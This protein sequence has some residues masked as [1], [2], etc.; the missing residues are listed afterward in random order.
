MGG[1]SDTGSTRS[2]EGIEERPGRVTQGDGARNT[3][4]GGT[5]VEETRE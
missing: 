3:R 1:G 4:V 5:G 2:A